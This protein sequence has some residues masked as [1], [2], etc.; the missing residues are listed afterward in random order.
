MPRLS[1]QKHNV[2]RLRILLELKQDGFARLVGCSI[3][4]LQSVESG[5][6]KLSKSLATQ[7]SAVTG[8]HVDWLLKN[9]LKSVPVAAAFDE[10]YPYLTGLRTQK[11]PPFTRETFRKAEKLQAIPEFI[12]LLIPGYMFSFYGQLRAILNSAAQNGHSAAAI[13]TVARWLDTLRKQFGHDSS[14]VPTPAL[15]LRGDGSAELTYRQRDSGLAVIKK[16]VAQWDKEIAATKAA[17][18]QTHAEGPRWHRKRQ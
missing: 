3:H 8:V 16:D 15:R 7:I 17:Q 18:Q 11:L 10:E 13:F 2:A 9:R 5:R 14:V 12:G 1:A 4:T 6:M